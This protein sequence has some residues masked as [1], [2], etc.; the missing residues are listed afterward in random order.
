MSD[1]RAIAAAAAGDIPS[2]GAARGDDQLPPETAQSLGARF[3]PACF[4]C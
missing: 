3:G 4:A 2:P 1:T